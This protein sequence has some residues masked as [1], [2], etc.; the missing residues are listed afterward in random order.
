MIDSHLTILTCT[1]LWAGDLEQRGNAN[2]MT[3]LGRSGRQYVVIANG[4][5][6]GAKLTAFALPRRGAS[7]VSPSG[8]QQ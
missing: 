1:Q 3:Y 6:V 5:G 8:P 4:S 7:G 2:P